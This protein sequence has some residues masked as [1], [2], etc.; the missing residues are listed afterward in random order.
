VLN[1]AYNGGMDALDHQA[2]ELIQQ[3]QQLR[4][5]LT[6][7]LSE[8]Y[9]KRVL[10]LCQVYL[11]EREAQKIAHQTIKEIVLI[12]DFDKTPLGKI[13][14]NLLSVQLHTL[15]RRLSRAR[16]RDLGMEQF[17]NPNGQHPQGSLSLKEKEDRILLRLRLDFKFPWAVVGKIMGIS[18]AA[19]K[20]RGHRLAKL[21]EESKNVLRGI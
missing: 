6:R 4:T 8:S 21:L 13:E 19:A 15:A 1:V 2:I 17:T 18:E 20:Q 11:P 16:A 5:K 7:L 12:W 9:G 3:I 14:G 10:A